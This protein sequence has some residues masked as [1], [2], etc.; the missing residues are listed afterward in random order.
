MKKVFLFEQPYLDEAELMKATSLRE[1][2]NYVVTR[3]LYLELSKNIQLKNT[4]EYSVEV[5][6]YRDERGINCRS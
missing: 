1:V 2:V 3:E 5:K 4:K 6:F